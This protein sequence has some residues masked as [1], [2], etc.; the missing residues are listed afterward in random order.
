MNVLGATDSIEMGINLWLAPQISEHCPYINPGRLIKKLIW[1]SRPGTAST[2]TPRLGIVH[3]WR[4][5]AEEIKLRICVLNGTI[6]WLSVSRRRGKDT[7]DISCE[8]I[9]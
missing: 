7:D 5:S 8:G 4:T 3:E 6:V 2:F 9:I 1:L